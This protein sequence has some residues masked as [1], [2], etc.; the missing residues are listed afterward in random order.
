MVSAAA[1]TRLCRHFWTAASHTIQMYNVTTMGKD[2]DMGRQD[3]AADTMEKDRDT[4][5]ADMAAAA[6]TKR[7]EKFSK[8]ATNMILVFIIVKLF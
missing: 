7:F 5:A 4:A 2:T 6:T 1:R 8:I 3:T